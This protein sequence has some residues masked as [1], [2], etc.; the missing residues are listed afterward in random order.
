[1]SRKICRWRAVFQYP[2]KGIFCPA[3]LW[4]NT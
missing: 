4:Y 3:I 1:M 2:W